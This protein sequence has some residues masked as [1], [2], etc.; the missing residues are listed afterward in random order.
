MSQLSLSRAEQEA[1]TLRASIDRCMREAAETARHTAAAG[2]ASTAAKQELA[3]LRDKCDVLESDCGAALRERAALQAALKDAQAHLQASVKQ[4]A[5][6]HLH[7]VDGAYA[8]Q[9]AAQ[10]ELAACRAALEQVR[11]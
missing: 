6:T 10:V 1:S 4:V 11:P 9:Q 3:V 5:D 2:A 7:H 8:V